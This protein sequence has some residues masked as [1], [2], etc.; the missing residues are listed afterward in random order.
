MILHGQE[1]ASIDHTVDIVI[2]DSREG[3]AKIE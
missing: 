2:V 3:A 1:M